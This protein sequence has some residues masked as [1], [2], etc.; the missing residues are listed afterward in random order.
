ME[1]ITKSPTNI[2]LTAKPKFNYSDFDIWPFESIGF[3][4]A[5]WAVYM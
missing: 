3:V 4:P 1:T 2:I 5:L